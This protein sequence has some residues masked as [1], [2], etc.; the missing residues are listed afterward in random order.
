MRPANRLPG[1]V[2]AYRKA[3]G[4]APVEPAPGVRVGRASAAAT[5]AAAHNGDINNPKRIKG[6]RAVDGAAAIK[7]GNPWDVMAEA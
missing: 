6:G 1:G 2:A 3:V 5:S 4:L 7:G